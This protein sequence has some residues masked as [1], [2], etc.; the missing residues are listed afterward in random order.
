MNSILADIRFALR[1]LRRSPGFTLTAVLT[2]SLTVGLAATVFS[3]FDALLI[4]PLP[5]GEPDRIVV[6]RPYSQSGYNQPASSPEY[7]FWREN[8]RSFTALAGFSEQTMNLR[9]PQGPAAIHAVHSTDNFF[10]ALGVHAILGRTFLPSENARGRTDVAVLSYTLWRKSFDGRKN[11]LGSKIELDGR[12]V[13]VVGVMPASFRFPLQQS[14]VAYTPFTPQE[15]DLSHTGRHWMWT[16]GHLKPGMTAAQAQ[17][18]MTRVLTAYAQVRPDS[19]GRRMQLT[20]MAEAVLGQTGGLVIVLALAVVAVLLLGCVNIAG[21][22][23]VRGLR[24]ERELA[25]RAAIGASRTRLARQLLSEIA[26][27][28]V[29]GTAGGAIAAFL[30]LQAV[31]TLLAASLD[32]GAEIALNAPVLLAS[33]LAALLTL[34][35]AGLLP[36]R[37]LFAVAPADALRNGSS[38]TGTNRTQQRL[39]AVFIATQMALAMVLLVTSGLLLRALSTLR[40]T[41]LGFSSDHL[42]VEDVALS[43]ETLEG[44]DLLQTFYNPL[45]ERVR[46]L[47]GVKSAAIINLLPVA[48]SGFNGDIQIVGHQP[49]PPNTE[50]LAEYRLISPGYHAAMGTRLLHGRLFDDRLDASKSQPVL[51]VNEAFVKKFFAP[52]EDPIGKH[53]DDNDVKPEII[54]VVSDQ[55]QNLFQPPL[56]ETDFPVSQ[57]SIKNHAQYMQDMQLVIRTTAYLDPLTLAEPLRK[58]MQQLDPG[59]PF[60]PAQTM[61]DVVGEALVLE[62]MEGWLFVTFA[63]L[64]VLLAALGL[65]GLTAQRVEQGRRDI[66][67]RMA[68]GAQRWQVLLLWLRRVAAISL[69]GL[70]AGLVLSFALRKV[71]ASVLTVRAPHEALFL[72]LLVLAMELVALLASAAPALRAA[73]VDPVEVLRAE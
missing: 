56:A 41:D 30:L 68:L 47:P 69:A 54:G 73:S 57:V 45:L 14:E 40:T 46:A 19:K 26:L 51:I 15:D 16:F 43:R 39:S 12:P 52:G 67:I 36:V 23:L 4:R 49:A 7:Q 9:G 53:I 17:A 61:T 48:V 24:R 44:R 8:N 59:L 37:Q 21:L 70:A 18:D 60:R 11:V 25:L 3:V 35:L 66:G 5:Y 38:G 20:S 31:H 58:I 55:R 42:L 28:A 6:L 27:L 2:L 62:R 65:Y 71:I 1:Q 22:M 72:T 32:R 63:A 34:L 29:A 13:T 64:A 10:D 33:L 50:Q